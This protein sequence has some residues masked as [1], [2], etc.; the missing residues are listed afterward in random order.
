MYFLRQVDDFA[1][2]C[3][4]QA[5]ANEIIDKIDSHM[6]IKVKPLGIISRFN[7]V[8]IKQT[9]YYI[10][11]SNA[12]YIE[13]IG[14]NAT[15][16]DKSSHHSPLP[17]SEDPAFNKEIENATPLDEKGLKAAEKKY[18]FSY[19]Q[20]IGEL[21]YAMVTCRPGIS[22]PLTKLSQ[23]SDKPA[24]MHFKAVN[25]LYSYL[26]KT[27][28][29][30]IYYW[31]RVPRDDLEEGPLPK[32]P[33]QN[34]YTPKTRSQ[35]NSTEVRAAVN[36]N[37]AG[38]STHRRSVTGIIIKIEGG[39]VFYKTRYQATISLSSTEAEFIAACDATK[40]ILYIRYILQDI[41]ISQEK[42]TTLFEDNQGALLM[43]NSGQPTKR[44]RHMDVKYFAIQSWVENDLLVLKRID[45]NDNEA[46]TM[47]KNVGRTM[48]YRHH[49]YLMGKIIP[50][51]A[52]MHK[53]LQI[54]T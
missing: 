26:K 6:T 16:T 40:I 21:I 39:S 25:G 44:T 52:K 18:G 43:A 34:N 41:G 47:T 29:E 51:Y 22:F 42:A 10:K 50:E 49:D 20:E 5:I 33:H 35:E 12:T 27:P 53:N 24:E 46:D 8:D 23:Y 30:S 28:E 17:M 11:V 2:S 37:Y 7:G 1:I 9:K 38:D 45:T 15:D 19:R 54:S 3:T 31:R 4:H 32:C 48:F 36:S 13:K 14:L